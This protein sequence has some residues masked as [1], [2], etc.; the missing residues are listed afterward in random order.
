MKIKSVH[1]LRA[2]CVAAAD[3]TLSTLMFR[4]AVCMLIFRDNRRRDQYKK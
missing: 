3:E 1:S 2:R 4:H